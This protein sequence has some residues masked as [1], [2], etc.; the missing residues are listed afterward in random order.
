MNKIIILALVFS[1]LM[2]VGVLGNIFLIDIQPLGL[3]ASL[4]DL[5]G[6]SCSCADS[7]GIFSPENCNQFMGD[8][9]D[10]PE[11]VCEELALA[12]NGGTQM[13]GD[14]PLETQGCNADIWLNN[15]FDPASSSI[16]PSGYSPNYSFNEIFQV[17]ITLPVE[18]DI[19]LEPLE[20]IT[21]SDTET[22][23]DEVATSLAVNIENSNSNNGLNLAEV[24]ELQG[25]P[26]NDLLRES[27][28]AI[29]NAAHS[30][31]DYPYTVAE[32]ITMTQIALA[33]EEYDET[34]IILKEANGIGN[35]PICNA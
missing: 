28:S 26:L 13:Y 19:P 5:P 30:E 14:T 33:N 9:T 2:G 29:L 20:N 17:I 12:L 4:D 21:S 23:E 15:Q 31:I 22:V 8:F 11:M 25:T 35:T 27:V 3:F 1:G 10:S 18:E 7:E 24:L 34:V 32:I 16:W 6:S